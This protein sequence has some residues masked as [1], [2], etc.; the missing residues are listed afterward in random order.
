MNWRRIWCATDILRY[1]LAALAGLAALIGIEWW[2]LE[3]VTRKQFFTGAGV[4]FAATMVLLT[5]RRYQVCKCDASPS[6]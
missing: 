6:E 1:S 5:I 3:N 2:M 4:L